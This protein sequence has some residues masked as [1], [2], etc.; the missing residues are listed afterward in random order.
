MLSNV[1]GNP[2]D[3]YAYFSIETWWCEGAWQYLSYE[4]KTSVLFPDEN[5]YFDLDVY[6]DWEA[7]LGDTETTGYTL[8]PE[9]PIPDENGHI[10]YVF[11]YTDTENSSGH[12]LIITATVDATVLTAVNG[13][14][15]R[16]SRQ[17]KVK[18]KRTVTTASMQS[19]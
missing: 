5:K 13:I 15:S 3:N 7:N 14:E 18:P 10:Q 1:D 9:N 4:I 8:T 19:M 17:A 11:T 16:S 12:D 6:N 2:N